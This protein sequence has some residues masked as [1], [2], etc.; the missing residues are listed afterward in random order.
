[1]ISIIM[2]SKGDSWERELKHGHRHLIQ[3]FCTSWVEYLFTNKEKLQ[4]G[5][6]APWIPF[7]YSLFFLQRCDQMTMKGWKSDNMVKAHVQ[8]GCQP[9]I[10]NNGLRKVFAFCQP[11]DTPY[12]TDTNLSSPWNRGKGG[13]CN[14]F[15][16]QK[17]L[18]L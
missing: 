4:L 14:Y 15:S 6:I 5:T 17:N 10:Q 16:S 8:V 2:L 11:N 7:I 13:V 3:M 12:A 18:N 9:L 1:M